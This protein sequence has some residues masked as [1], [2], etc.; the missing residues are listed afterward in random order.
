MSKFLY[1]LFSTLTLKAWFTY[2]SSETYSKNVFNKKV[3]CFVSTLDLDWW[4]FWGGWRREFTVFFIV[5]FVILF[6]DCIG[7]P[8]I[9]HHLWWCMTP[10]FCISNRYRWILTLVC[11]WSSV[12]YLCSS[13]VHY[14]LMLLFSVIASLIV[15]LSFIVILLTDSH[16]FWY[17]VWQLFII[18][19]LILIVNGFTNLPSRVT[20]ALSW[21]KCFTHL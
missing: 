18:F 1:N 9:I 4:H 20:L 8:I 16:S 5:N 14:F 21:E 2:E 11:Y 17:G 7:R 15:L 3:S 13:H 12:I 19:S 6:Q 10:L